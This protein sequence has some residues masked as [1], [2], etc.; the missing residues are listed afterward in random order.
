MQN[1]LPAAFSKLQ[2]EQRIGPTNTK[3][4]TDS[5]LV[6]RPCFN[7][8]FEPSTYKPRGRMKLTGWVFFNLY[9]EDEWQRVPV[10]L[11]HLRR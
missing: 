5:P 4:T 8:H 9:D 3:Q 1:F 10:V 11:I 2:L 7:G 6:A